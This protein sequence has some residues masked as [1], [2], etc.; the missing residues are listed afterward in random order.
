MSSALVKLIAFTIYYSV[1]NGVAFAVTAPLLRDVGFTSLD[2]GFAASIAAAAALVGTLVG[3]PLSDR[4]AAKPLLAVS[5]LVASPAYALVSQATFTWVAAGFALGSFFG[6][7]AGIASSVLV[8]RIFREE[9]Y[10]RVYS[11]ISASNA[12]GGGVG[13]LLGWIP[14]LLGGASVQSYQLTLLT[15]SLLAPCSILF[16]HGIGRGRPTRRV[17][18]EGKTAREALRVIA[19]FAVVEALIGFGAAASIHII[20][21]YFALKYGVSS[22]EL[23]TIFGLESLLLGALMTLMPKVSK[24]VG[25]PLKAY[26]LVSSTSIP[27]L[28]AITFVNNLYLAATLYIARTVLMNVASPLLQAFQMRIVPSGYRGRAMSAFIIA[29]QLP[30]VAG[31]GVGGY[32]MAID[33]ELP[34]RVTSAIYAVGL[35]LL[36]TL[37]REHLR[38]KSML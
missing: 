2:Y 15:L 3:G 19:K 33:V 25:S 20:D 29:W 1:L 31:R 16:L 6:S 21:F 5:M 9:E 13:G 17:K 38:G 18:V 32:L 8:A 10:E 37:F 24:M 11:Y 22:A 12:I 27:L 36:A 30:A 14:V 34:L 4:V 28:L 35:S 7:I 23:G 26:V